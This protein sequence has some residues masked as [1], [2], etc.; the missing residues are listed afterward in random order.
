M[1]KLLSAALLAA[2]AVQASAL[3]CAP[4]PQVQLA[5]MPERVLLVGESHGTEQAPAFVARLAC[6]LVQAG[7]PVIVAVER[8]VQEQPAIDAYLASPGASADARALLLQGDWANE[9]QD[10]RSSAAMLALL[11]QVRRWHQAG[12]PVRVLALRQP[13]RFDGTPPDASV[14]QQAVDRG[15]ADTLSGA[16][17]DHPR[18]TAI[19][20]AGTFHTA[21]ASKMHEDF[22]H[23]PSMGDLLAQRGPVH[24]IGPGSGAGG[25]SWGMVNQQQPGVQPQAAGQ[26]DLPDARVDTRVDLGPLTASKP[27]R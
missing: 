10:G 6:L 25:Q 13:L 22:V 2:I 5:R 20:L 26:F 16:L 21:V 3:D 18:H 4:E 12:Q 11:D 1:K 23:G 8:D 7:R 17:K 27:A 15:M 19:V 24:V 14:L 9:R